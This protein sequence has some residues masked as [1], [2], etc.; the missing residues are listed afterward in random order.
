MI[1]EF[2]NLPP[3]TTEQANVVAAILTA[4]PSLTDMAE[5]THYD[6][7]RF[8]DLY[9]S[10]EV[11]AHIRAAKAATTDHVTIRL[12]EAAHTAISTLERI[13]ED[14]DNDKTERRRAATTV[15]RCL[16]PRPGGGGVKRVREFDGG[17]PRSRNLVRELE[18]ILRSHDPGGGGVR[19]VRESDGGGPAPSPRLRGEC[20]GEGSASAQDGLDDLLRTLAQLGGRGVRRARESDAPYPSPERVLSLAPGAT[21]GA[22]T[23]NISEPGTGEGPP[24]TSAASRSR[25]S[26]PSPAS[27]LEASRPQPSHPPQDSNLKTQDPTHRPTERAPPRPAGISPRHQPQPV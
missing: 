2:T 18:S 14:T 21:R 15:L 4:G 17:G 6:L 3:L 5:A 10:P 16:L 8:L 26:S 25:T 22:D 13:A 19:R 23:S 9:S 12:T 7:A 24:R 20:W 27:S 11:R 1:H